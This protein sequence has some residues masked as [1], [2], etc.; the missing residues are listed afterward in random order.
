M[1]TK[2]P[3]TKVGHVGGENLREAINLTKSSAPNL[4]I[5]RDN[6]RGFASMTSDEESGLI[7]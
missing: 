3:A 2:T 6:K 5:S 4:F 1:N 7:E